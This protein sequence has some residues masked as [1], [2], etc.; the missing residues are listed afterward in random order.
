V[1]DDAGQW[2]LVDERYH[3]RVSALVGGF[4]QDVFRMEEEEEK[5]KSE[6]REREIA[7]RKSVQQ[8]RAPQAG[9][10]PSAPDNGAALFKDADWLFAKE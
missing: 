7:R 10:Q 3:A 4:I 5:R 8:A 9:Q 6:E 2:V 1:I